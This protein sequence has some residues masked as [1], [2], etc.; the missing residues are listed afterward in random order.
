MGF[1][2]DLRRGILDPDSIRGKALDMSQYKRLFGTARIPTE[3][4]PAPCNADPDIN[5][6]CSAA[7]GWSLQT[8]I[9]SLSFDEGSSVRQIVQSDLL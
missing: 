7:V 3:V 9:I 4:R 2:H 1:I 6:S 8:P 5:L